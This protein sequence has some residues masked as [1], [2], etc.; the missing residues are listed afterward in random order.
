MARR[1][2]LELGLMRTDRGQYIDKG[3]A[4]VDVR[5]PDFNFGA[6]GD[7]VNDDGIA[8]NLALAH[9]PTE[10][11]TVFVPPGDY[12]LTT[13]FS[14]GAKDN[15][16][17][18][19]MPGVVLTGEALPAATGN[20][21]IQ[22]WRGASTGLADITRVNITAGAGLTGSVDTTTGVHTQTLDV[23]GTADRITVAADAIDI[24]ATYVGQATITTLGTIATGA[25][26]ASLVTAGTFGTGA[27]IF[28]D[29]L[30]VGGNIVVSGAGPHAIGRG[31]VDY[32]RMIVSGSFTSGG[33]ATEASLWHLEGVLTGASGDTTFLVGQNIKP[34]ITT[35]TATESIG[36]VAS[37]MFTEPSITDNLTGSITIAA[38]V[39]IAGA[40]TEGVTNAAL[41][42]N[43]GFSFFR[44]A[45]ASPEVARF[46]GGSAIPYITLNVDAGEVARISASN[47]AGNALL[48]G[49]NGTDDWVT[50]G[51]TGTLAVSTPG[52]HAF[53]GAVSNSTQFLIQGAFAA[54]TASTASY[55]F[56]TG[57]TMT[58]AAGD[59]TRLALAGFGGTITTQTETES[60]GVVANA[61]FFDPTIT[62]NLTGNITVAA[63][64]YIA[65]APTEGVTN[66][67]LYV[68]AGD[69]NF[70]GSFAVG[71]SVGVQ[72]A[73]ILQA[74]TGA[75]VMKLDH[76]H[77]TAPLGLQ[78]QFSGGAPDDNTQW[79]Y[80]AGD[81]GAT[82]TINYSDGDVWTVDAGTL[83][84]DDRVKEN[85]IPA[86]SKLDDV[87]A[88]EVYNYN[89]TDEYHTRGSE[90]QMR[91]RIGFIS[92]NV[93]SIFPGLVME[94]NVGPRDADGNP[95][96]DVL[97]KSV[98]M[99]TIGSPILVK[100]FQEYVERTDARMAALEAR[101]GPP[102]V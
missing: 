42:V 51:P 40:P 75:A 46:V 79:F 14:F 55:G 74:D 34:V 59:V 76:T 43:D 89:F 20:N 61:I 9:L 52:P 71:T 27:Y 100:A 99:G 58:G 22:D 95:L 30:T 33:A 15:V 11:G 5:H 2:E 82:R 60:I 19:I 62:D 23:V 81:T 92:S 45:G 96:T 68:A 80:L 66:A 1:H 94:H 78:I 48:L 72:E 24:A 97:T 10:G 54:G 8:W 4:W 7:G 64:V 37:A 83:T 86:T 91:K 70:Q 73:V 85:I 50:I 90:S 21:F 16:M 3:N 13:A 41:Y 84:S 28:D 98:R 29:N 32:D 102:V 26:P 47:T 101:A 77:A 35:Q 56:R 65:G 57:M 69:V 39:Y 6:K 25:I 38:T 93:E 44:V 49:C 18:W 36:I 12:L 67:A 17:L 53:G 87:L 31:V 63:T 88:L